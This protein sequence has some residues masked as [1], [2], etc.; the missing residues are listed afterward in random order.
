LF[1]VFSV[2]FSS[3]HSHT[4]FPI[5]YFL[6]SFLPFLHFSSSYFPPP[7]FLTSFFLILSFSFFLLL[8]FPSLFPS[9]SF[10]SLIPFSL[11]SS[12]L[13]L[14]HTFLP[15]YFPIFLLPTFFLFP[16]Q[17]HHKQSFCL[18]LLSLSVMAPSLVPSLL[19]RYTVDYGPPQPVEDARL[20]KLIQAATSLVKLRLSL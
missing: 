12:L 10:V 11:P 17:D 15:S 2:S 5:F 14:L 16:L 8:H 6:F 4:P 18:H 7:F 3:S 13:P 20:F 9:A 1:F 19:P